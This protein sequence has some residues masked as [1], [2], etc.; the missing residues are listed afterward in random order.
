[1]K[2]RPGKIITLREGACH[3]EESLMRCDRCDAAIIEVD[4]YG[5]RL[6][7]C[8]ECN[9]WWGS[10]PAFITELSVE[11][12]EALR[13]SKTIGH[14]HRALILLGKLLLNPFPCSRSEMPATIVPAAMKFLRPFE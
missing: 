1:V 2:R 13:R 8:L 14:L 12:F 11:D 6:A 3:Q 5:E 9:V 4:H 7:G 10:K